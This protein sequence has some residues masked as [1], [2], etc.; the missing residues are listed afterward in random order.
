MEHGPKR[1]TSSEGPDAANALNEESLTPA[2]LMFGQRISALSEVDGLP[3]EHFEVSH[4]DLSRRGL[5]HFWTAWKVA[6]LI[7]LRNAHSR[8]KR[9]TE[10]RLVSI[11]N[12]ALVH[13]ETHTRTCWKIGRGERILTSK[14]GQI[15]GA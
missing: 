13:H 1:L 14:D 7:E 10:S 12:L 4:G 11:G 5:S 8:A 6:Y 2:N 15:R 9:T 3:D